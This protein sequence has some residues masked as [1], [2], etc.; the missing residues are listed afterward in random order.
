MKKKNEYYTEDWM[1]K[2]KDPRDHMHG[3]YPAFQNYNQKATVIQLSN[4][5]YT[6]T[7][8]TSLFMIQQHC[9]PIIV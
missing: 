6:H 7:T 8:L 2:I 4:V 5:R 9:L 3:C 1:S